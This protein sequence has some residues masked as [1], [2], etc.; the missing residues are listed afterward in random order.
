[1]SSLSELSESYSKRLK[2]ASNKKLVMESI[3]EEIEGLEYTQTKKTISKE[4][5][6]KI[7]E[8]IKHNIIGD[9]FIKEADNKEYLALINYFLSKLED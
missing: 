6:K 2:S 7:L 3:F 9:V 8:Q 5:E 1:M 4:D